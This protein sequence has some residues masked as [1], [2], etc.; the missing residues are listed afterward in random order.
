MTEH[1][2]LLLEEILHTLEAYADD[3][4]SAR[5]T[6]PTVLIPKIREA[7]QRHNAFERVLLSE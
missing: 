6:D 7:L 1:T 2:G 3:H 4:N 5:P